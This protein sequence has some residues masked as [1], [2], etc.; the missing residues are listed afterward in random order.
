MNRIPKRREARHSRRDFAKMMGL[1]VAA[2]TLVPSARSGSSPEDTQVDSLVKLSTEN[3]PVRLSDAELA[4]LKKDI[5]EGQK[6]LAKIREFKVPAD[7]EP[8]FVF[9]AKEP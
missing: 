3:A 1:G 6:G 9:R 8:A 4:D 5:Q 2:S 7:I